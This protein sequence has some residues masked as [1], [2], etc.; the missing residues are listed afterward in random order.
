MT[1]KNFSMQ[2]SSSNQIMIYRFKS[3]EILFIIHTN[4][5]PSYEKKILPLYSS[6][7]TTYNTFVILVVCMLIHACTD[8]LEND[9]HKQPLNDTI[10]IALQPY[11]NGKQAAISLTFD[12]GTHDQYLHAVSSL[13]ERGLKGTFFITG[14]IVFKTQ[15]EGSN[16]MTHNEVAEIYKKGHEIGNHTFHHI[17]LTTVSID[18]AKREIEMNDSAIISWIGVRPKTFAFPYNSRNQRL[19]E[20]AQDGRIAAR[21][22]E[23]GFGQS[24]SHTTLESANKWIENI[25]QNKQWGICMFHGIETGYD[26]WDSKDAFCKVIDLFIQYNDVWIAPFQDIAAYTTE[27]KHAKIKTSYNRGKIK[28]EIITGLNPSLFCHPLTISIYINGKQRKMLN[29][30]PNKPFE[31]DIKTNIYGI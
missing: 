11:Y 16:R 17:D 30:E 6:M 8:N 18:S 31:I 1:I 19:I 10:S 3:I 5:Y 2:I 28:G 22:F 24:E 4:T 25:R 20:L 14:S 27:F 26:H 13:D 7:N 21:T 23:T 29:I 9:I 12:D 15:P